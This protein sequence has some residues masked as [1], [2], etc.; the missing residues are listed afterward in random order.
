MLLAR[1]RP[2]SSFLGCGKLSVRS[3][4]REPCSHQLRWL[5]LGVRQV[6][7]TE[8]RFDASK[9]ANKVPSG[10]RQRILDRL[11]ERRLLAAA[12]LNDGTSAATTAA[13]IAALPDGSAAAAAA[14]AAEEVRASSGHDCSPHRG[15]NV[16]ARKFGICLSFKGFFCRPV[17]NPSVT[18]RTVV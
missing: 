8:V 1:E 14:A 3:R 6:I 15:L 17:R 2:W 4:S 16:T 18:I 12:G 7:T 13:A 10:L 5:G 9:K 11:V